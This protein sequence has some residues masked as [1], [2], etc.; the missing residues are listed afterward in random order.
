MMSNWEMKQF[1]DANVAAFDTIQW[2]D[3][4][5]LP[6]REWVLGEFSV[7]LRRNLE[8]L[9]ADKYT[10]ERHDCDD[11]ARLAWAMAGLCHNL[12]STRKSALAFGLLTYTTDA[13]GGHAINFA[14]VHNA[15]GERE[16]MFFEPQTQREVYL[17][18][19]ERDNAISYIV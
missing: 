1:M 8:L 5:A 9:G 10:A 4:Y 19:Q 11:F 14:V 6:T 16:I 2:D 15:K 13:G 12:T 17:S 3:E 7:A 18:Q